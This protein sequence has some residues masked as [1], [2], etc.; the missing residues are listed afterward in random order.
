MKTA[1]EIKATL[2]NFTGTQTWFKHTVPGVTYTEGV[3]YLAEAAE[4]YWLLD[5]LAIAQMFPQ[6]SKD[7]DLQMYQFWTLKVHEDSS[8][9]LVCE[10]DKNYPV[11]K[12][13][14]PF[15]DF[16]LSEIQIWVERKVILLPSEH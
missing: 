2:P 16:P 7:K 14:I 6:I 4:C 8:A 11:Y 13:E 10:K 5:E 9:T 12:K 3:Q 15:T 1:E